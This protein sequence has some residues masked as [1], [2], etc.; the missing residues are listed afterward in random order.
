MPNI[1]VSYRWQEQ[2]KGRTGPMRLVGYTTMALF[3]IAFG[4]WATLAPIAGATIAPGIIAAA[5][6]NVSIQHLEGGIVEYV[7]AHEGD[8]VSKGD[9]L[10]VL[11][12]TAA[13]VQ[14]NRLLEQ[15]I[16][17]EAQIARFEAERDGSVALAIPD[18][19]ENF[20]PPLDPKLEFY[21][22]KKQF[23]ARKARYD[24]QEQI[25]VQRRNSL[26]DAMNGLQAQKLAI[27]RQ[28][29]I[30]D[31]EASIQRQLLDKGLTTRNQL[32]GLE[33]S[34]ADLT[35]QSGALTAQIAS[36]VSQIGEALAQIEQ[37]TTSRVEE[38]VSDLNTTRVAVADL[39]EQVRAARHVLARTMVRAPAD[40]VVV[41]S[42]HNSRGSV[43]RPGEVVIELL[44]TT[45]ELIVEARI[46]PQEIDSVKLDQTA[47]MALIA[48]N[49]R[50]T[51][52]LRGK[53]FYISA[54][55]LT[56]PDT[57]QAYYAVRLKIDQ[58]LPP[59]IKTDQIYPGMPVQA[60]I[61]TGTR[62]FVDY[63]LRPILDSMDLAFRQA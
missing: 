35:G 41:Q 58:D 51:P 57:G 20:P 9:V 31:G 6:Q 61:S 23:L 62:S 43:V 37:L 38:A 46:Q 54:D 30:L 42:V 34:I 1:R 40:G 47:E 21:E 22:Q 29:A 32:M 44:P 2:V 12:D 8:H 28:L 25:L 13:Q 14:L 36:M 4:G 17:S 56:T 5:G 19:F 24:S 60:F 33:R 63:L 50:V 11:D 15:V 27:E 16:A 10:L 49:T 45:N 7:V 55:H 59:E 26:Q 39:R 3:V 48:L 18:D 52:K 53:V